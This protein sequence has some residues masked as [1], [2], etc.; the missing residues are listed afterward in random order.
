MQKITER[1][2]LKM[3]DEAL[4][5]IYGDFMDTYSA[6]RVLKEIDPIAYRV[7]FHEYIGSLEEDGYEIEGY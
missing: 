2:A 4:G 1:E 5:E 3:Y 6:S 7:G